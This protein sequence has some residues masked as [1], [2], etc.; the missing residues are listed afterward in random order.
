MAIFTFIAVPLL[1]LERYSTG[2]VGRELEIMSANTVRQKFE[3]YT[4]DEAQ[5][6]FTNLCDELAKGGK[7][8]NAWADTAPRERAPN[9]FRAAKDADQFTRDINPE[10]VTVYEKAA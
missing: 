10:L 8:W 9:G 5:R 2:T 1:K 3:A 4:V 6:G 7:S